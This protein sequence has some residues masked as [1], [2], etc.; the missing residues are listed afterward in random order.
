MLPTFKAIESV[1]PTPDV[2]C[3]VSVEPVPVPPKT[4]GAVIEVVNVGV[5]AKATTVPEPVVVYEVPHAVP[6]ELGIPAPG[7]TIVL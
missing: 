1:A 3:S 7:Y 4:N 5:V 2:D 6:V